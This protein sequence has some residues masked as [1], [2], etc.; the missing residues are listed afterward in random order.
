MSMTGPDWLPRLEIHT[1]VEREENRMFVA[2][3]HD[4]D[5]TVIGL[6]ADHEHETHAATLITLVFR[7][8]A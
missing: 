1:Q 2:T 7:A 4:M 6:Q 8:Q 5:P 3:V